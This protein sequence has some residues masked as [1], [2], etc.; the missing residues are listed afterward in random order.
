MLSDIMCDFS[1]PPPRTLRCRSVVVQQQHASLLR[2][3]SRGRSTVIRSPVV[4][5][6]RTSAPSTATNDTGSNTTPTPETTESA[7]T[8]TVSINVE[9]S[10][11]AVEVV[12][13]EA[14]TTNLLDNNEEGNAENMD[15]SEPV[16]AAGEGISNFI[17]NF[18]F[19]AHFKSNFL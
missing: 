14:D 4:A 16:I 12:I 18:A 3:G 11:P 15:T 2:S 6:A 19:L 5:V 8:E 9:A 17:K 10:V 1:Q 7:P 13:E